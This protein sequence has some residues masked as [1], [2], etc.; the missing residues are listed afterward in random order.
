MC[1]PKESTQIFSRPKTNKWVLSDPRKKTSFVCFVDVK[2]FK[3]R[4]S[5]NFLRGWLENSSWD[6]FC[7]Q[8]CLSCMPACPISIKHKKVYQYSSLAKTRKVNLFNSYQHPNFHRQEFFLLK[9]LYNFG[10]KNQNGQILPL[11]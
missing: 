6:V 10:Y 1:D 3:H 2:L 7:Q 11:F 9:I 4:V 8:M 5:S